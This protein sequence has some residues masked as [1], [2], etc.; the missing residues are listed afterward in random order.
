MAARI[1]LIKTLKAL[2]E[3]ERPGN[4]RSMTVF[5]NEAGG[6]NL[7]RIVMVTD[8]ITVTGEAK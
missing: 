1:E 6:R 7:A 3:P 5:E 8:S 4:L 2:V